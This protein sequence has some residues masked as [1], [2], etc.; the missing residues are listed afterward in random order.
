MNIAL[1]FS[2][3]PFGRRVGDEGFDQIRRTKA[4]TRTLSQRE[5][6]KECSLYF[7]LV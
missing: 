2:L 7:F 3:L 1:F 5:R 4:L 6:E